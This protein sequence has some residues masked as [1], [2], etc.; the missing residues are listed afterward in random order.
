MN[1]TS[2]PKYSKLRQTWQAPEAAAAYRLSRRPERSKRFDRKSPSW[3]MA[4]RF[5]GNSLVL[6][7]PAAPAGVCRVLWTGLWYIGADISPP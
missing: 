5:G 2:D 6:D 7:I 1:D 3:D 4:R